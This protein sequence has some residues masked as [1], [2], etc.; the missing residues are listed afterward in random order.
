MTVTVAVLEEGPWMKEV[1]VKA[2]KEEE[3]NN[4][5]GLPVG[6]CA[7]GIINLPEK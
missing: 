3:M 1:S 7:D 4:R 2:V 6:V 5:G